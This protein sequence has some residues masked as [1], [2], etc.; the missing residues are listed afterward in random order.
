MEQWCGIDVHER[1]NAAVPFPVFVEVDSA[2]AAHAERLYGIGESLSSFY[3]LYLGVGL[4]G[5][6][7]FDSQVMRGA[8]GNA[9]EIGHIPLVPGGDVCSCGNLGCL[10]RYLSL[11]AYERRYAEVSEA[12]W[13]QEVAPIFR[14]AVVTIEN[15]FDPQ[16]VVLGGLAPIELRQKLVDLAAELPNSLAAWRDRKFPRVVL[17]NCGSDVVIRG[18]ASLAVSRVLSP[19]PT[20]SEESVA[21]ANDPFTRSIYQESA[22]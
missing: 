12:V 4:G 9:G 3:Y 13:L 1:L 15:L 10:E 8:W 16:A 19:P 22:A 18:A 5:S 21:E 7:V 17:S 14:A 2:A 11:E 6:A 20:A